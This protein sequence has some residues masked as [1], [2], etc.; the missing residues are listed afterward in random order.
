MQTDQLSQS[1]STIS[2]SPL[3][4]FTIDLTM[5]RNEKY[6]CTICGKTFKKK[7]DSKFHNDKFHEKAK[8]FCSICNNPFFN[9]KDARFHHHQQPGLNNNN[10][11]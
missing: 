3:P 5:D 7:S 10:N 11:E 1:S 9:D 6:M 8:F 4:S 2:Q